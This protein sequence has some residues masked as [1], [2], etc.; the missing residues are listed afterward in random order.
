ML[1]TW[2]GEKTRGSDRSW[3]AWRR[4]LYGSSY[5]QRRTHRGAR[6]LRKEPAEMSVLLVTGGSRGIG[7]AIVE[8]FAIAGYAVAFTYA[9]NREVAEAQKT[10][11]IQQGKKAATYQADV[12]NFEMAQ[13]VVRQV[14]ECFGPVDVLVSQARSKRPHSATDG[15]G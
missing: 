4:A 6:T 5:S 8:E 12:R 13:A 14:Q 1:W 15:F 3:G 2:K 11:L 9:R 10:C 7:R